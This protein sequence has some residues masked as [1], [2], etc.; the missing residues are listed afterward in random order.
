MT[1]WLFAVIPTRAP[2]ATSSQTIR[3]PGVGLSRSR[4]G[5]ARAAHRSPSSQATRSAASSA[6][7]SLRRTGSPPRRGGSRNRR[8]RAA[9]VQSVP[10]NASPGYV[11]T[12]SEQRVPEDIRVH[13]VVREHGVGMDTRRC[14][15]SS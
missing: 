1:L 2:W 12:D 15:P 8:S 5:P 10:G 11:L 14:H 6:V 13:E 3:A 4:V 7:S 9:A